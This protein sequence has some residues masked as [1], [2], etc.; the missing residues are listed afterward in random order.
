MSKDKQHLKTL[1]ELRKVKADRD[2][3]RS[4]YEELR[5]QVRA[6]A[7]DPAPMARVTD[8][9]TPAIRTFT[10]DEVVGGWSDPDNA[11]ADSTK[12]ELADGWRSIPG[13][14]GAD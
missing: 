13:T 2:F 6:I 12:E 4:R 8:A 7:R 9:R 1:D 11:S 3:W 14:G 10:V 5:G